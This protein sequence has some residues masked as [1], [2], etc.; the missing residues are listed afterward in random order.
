MLAILNIACTCP[1]QSPHGCSPLAISITVHPTLHTSAAGWLP[2]P[3]CRI[4]SGA[5]QYA[6][7]LNDPP[8]AICSTRDLAIPKSASLIL[9]LFSTRMFPPLM[10][11]C[12]HRCECR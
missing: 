5:I 7:P 9:P 11:L 8:S 4:T 10:S 6:D 3:F 1:L 2:L 12:T